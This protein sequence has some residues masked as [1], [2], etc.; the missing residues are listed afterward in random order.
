MGGV[1]PCLYF[2]VQKYKNIFNKQVP[3]FVFL[4]L[5]QAKTRENSNINDKR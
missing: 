2:S 5:K 4:I 3:F 1:I